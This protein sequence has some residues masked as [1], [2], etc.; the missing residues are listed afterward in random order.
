M[1]ERDIDEVRCLKSDLLRCRA[2]VVSE[3]IL[4][5]HGQCVHN[6]GRED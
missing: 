1:W 6:R 4:V 3:R 5:P 2:F